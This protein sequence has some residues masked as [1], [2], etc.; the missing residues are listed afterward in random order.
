MQVVVDAVDAIEADGYALA[1]LGISLISL[2]RAMMLRPYGGHRQMQ[3]LE[4]GIPYITILIH[5]DQRRVVG[6]V[7]ARYQNFINYSKV[8]QTPTM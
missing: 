8:I 1:A 4:F 3:V 5:Q 6:M 2:D 7:L